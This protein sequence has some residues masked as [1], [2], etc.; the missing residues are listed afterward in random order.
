[1]LLPLNKKKLCDYWKT[2]VTFT[3]LIVEYQVKKLPTK[4]VVQIFTVPAGWSFGFPDM[5]PLQNNIQ[6]KFSH[7]L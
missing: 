5:T 7:F 1:M 4:I 3:A 2:F 6:Q